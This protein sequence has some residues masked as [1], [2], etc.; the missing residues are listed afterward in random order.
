MPQN[1]RNCSVCGAEF[2]LHFR[3]QVEERVTAGDDGTDKVSVAFF[4]SQRCLEASHHARSG[5]SVQCD[6]CASSFEVELAYQVL[7]TGGRRHYACS[8]A[9]RSRIKD[10]TKAIRLGELLHPDRSDSTASAAQPAF[11]TIPAPAPAAFDAELPPVLDPARTSLPAPPRAP[12]IQLG[13]GA[14]YAPSD[15]PQVLAI[16]NH[17]GGTGKT[18][19]AVTIAAGLA[20]HGRRV[21]LVDTDG[22]GNVAASFGMKVVRSLYHVLVMGVPVS[23]AAVTVRE[24][25][26]VLPANETLA[27]AELYLAGRRNR[28]RILSQRL[29]D[30]RSRYDHVIVDCSP[31]LSLLNQNALV[32][33]DGVLCPVACDYLSLIGVRQ[34]LRT[35]KHV[36]Q[37]LGHPVHF[38]GLLPT[39]YDARAKICHEA[40]EAL[41][42]HFGERCLEPIRLAIKVKEAP[43]QAKTLLEYAPWSGAAS[44]YSSVVMRLL[45]RADTQLQPQSKPRVAV[46]TG[47]AR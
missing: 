35:I 1:H 4:C 39:M 3:Y 44:D 41:R 40:L 11:D 32:M 16:F 46:A 13:S 31:S 38:W 20:A 17:K 9:C 26:D 19:T 33:A 47:G 29:F 23:D 30:V 36:T 24:R 6:A 10:G 12:V 22:Q 43:S 8:P 28:D 27:A 2:E 25:L 14:P 18:T 5:G 37:H 45:G 34:V 42:D 15:T 7:F 21:L